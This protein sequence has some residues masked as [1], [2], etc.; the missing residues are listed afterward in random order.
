MRRADIRGPGDDIILEKSLVM[1]K[2]GVQKAYTFSSVIAYIPFVRLDEHETR[3]IDKSFELLSP[4]ESKIG[5]QHFGQ[6]LSAI[7]KYWVLFH[8]V[9]FYLS[10]IPKRC[11]LHTPVSFSSKYICIELLV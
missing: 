11:L 6:L 4:F 10:G 3:S 1:D 7:M 5:R 9:W 2:L 8:E